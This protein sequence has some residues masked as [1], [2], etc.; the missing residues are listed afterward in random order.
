MTKPKG[1]RRLSILAIF[2]QLGIYIM[3]VEP[4]IAQAQKEQQKQE[5]RKKEVRHLISLKMGIDPPYLDAKDQQLM[6]KVVGNAD[7]YLSI[8]EEIIL[9]SIKSN[10]WRE[11][12]AAISLLAMMK[13]PH[14][15]PIIIAALEKIQP[16]IEARPHDV[17][18]R[19]FFFLEEDT[20]GYLAGFRDSKVIELCFSRLVAL[21]P[22]TG[23]LTYLWYLRTSCV[24][25][26]KV[27]ARL[28]KLLNNPKSILYKNSLAIETVDIIRKGVPERPTKTDLR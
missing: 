12:G 23:P 19:R 26:Q 18:I 20:V 17:E 5:Q 28:E 22:E 10:D 7:A 11:T 4:A 13:T 8:I 16:I 9:D 25:D 3:G 14:R 24:G 1:P 27:A 6:D 15:Y 21:L 2:L